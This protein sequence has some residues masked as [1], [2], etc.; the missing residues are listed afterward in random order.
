VL[1]DSTGSLLSAP[2]SHYTQ[3][4]EG[5]QH[6]AHNGWAGQTRYKYVPLS[7]F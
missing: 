3:R 4:P 1:S 6:S 2:A 5:W 7:L